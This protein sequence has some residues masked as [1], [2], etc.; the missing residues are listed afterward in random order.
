MFTLEFWAY[1]LSSSVT[2]T[3]AKCSPSL[4]T[5]NKLPH[6]HNAEYRM[7]NMETLNYILEEFLII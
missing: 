3:L 5:D 6:V 1:M 2:Q 7:H 4:I